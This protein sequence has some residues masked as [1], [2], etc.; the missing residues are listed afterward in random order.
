L[1]RGSRK[2]PYRYTL[3]RLADALAL[4][5]E[6]RDELERSS[7]RAR[8][9]R[10]DEAAV[11]PPHRLPRQLTAF[12]GRA[13][14]VQEII[15]LL[16]AGPMVSIVG[17]GGAGKT[18]LAVAV[19]NALLGTF[20]DGVWFADLAPVL[21]PNRVTQAIAA[22]LHVDESPTRSPAE[23]LVSYLAH[24]RLLIILDNCEHVMPGARAIAG[25]VL[26]ECS[27]VALLAT[28]REA[29]SVA[30][31]RAYRIPSLAFP[32]G[33]PTPEEALHYGAVELFVD[34]MRAVD[35]RAAL[36]AENVEPI[37][38]I[39]LRLDGL[40]LALELAA[41]RT[42]LLSPAQLCAGL[43]RIFDV[44][45]KNDGT[46]ISRHATMRAAIDW[47]YALLAPPARLLFARLAIFVGGFSLESAG[48]V[49]CDEQLLPV[50]LLDMLSALAAQSL[51][52]VDIERGEARYHVLE[53]TRQYALEKLEQHG[54]RARIEQRHASAFVRRAERLH[55]DWYD[56]PE[57]T[58]FRQAEEE[59]GNFRAA[60]NWSLAEGHDAGAGSVLAAALAR[61]WYSIAPVEGQRWVRL[62]LASSD[63][64]APHALLYVADA[65]LCG[66]LGEYTASLAAAQR[67]MERGDELEELQRARA[68]QAAGSALGALERPAEGE[69][70]L[71]SALTRARALRNR[72]MEALVLGDLGT[73]RS[74][75][76]DIEGARTFY[77][78]ALACY[79][80][81]HFERP[82]AS[83]AG[84]LAEVEFA[85]GDAASALQLAEQARAAHE[86]TQNRR[87]F[88]NDL[89]NMAAYLVALDCFDDARAIGREALAATRDVKRTVLTACVLQH[90]AAVAVLAP[91]AGDRTGDA[92]LERAATVLGFVDAWLTKLEAPREYTERQ[93][94]ER[95][96]ASLRAT[97]GDR[98]D[99][100]LARGGDWTED[101]AI[102]AALA[103]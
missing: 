83:I 23:T 103:L 74:R 21:D 68:E 27:E 36:T 40:P 43:D 93:E 98:L 47:S 55:R 49:C 59:V 25:T 86:A 9:Q 33:T 75:R 31:E 87:S 15:G 91:H 29:L 58:W 92:V 28:S 76:G 84:N 73:A 10:L 80:A 97:L 81:L 65:E 12:F 7:R 35:T 99:G 69:T 56:A 38:E 61:V 67:A 96:V 64:P 30:G 46:N 52:A 72:R 54:E 37:V 62:A 78:E 60:L 44:L 32:R 53:A 90:L 45:T 79:E 77:A 11:T 66:S 2:N 24:K 39:C 20:P 1:E 4:T 18:R 22:A 13:E 100:M 14:S 57:R 17:T 94:Y 6:E 63:D 41:A 82:A 51:I 88:A 42:T 26:R 34:R 95:I 48:E 70:L 16:T 8:G 50:A 19:G 85:A 89:A 102:G 101:A 71:E 3:D 5:A